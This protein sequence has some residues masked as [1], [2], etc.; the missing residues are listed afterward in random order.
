MGLGR[1]WRTPSRERSGVG[2]RELPRELEARDRLDERAE[3]LEATLAAYTACLCFTTTACSTTRRAA[4]QATPVALGDSRSIK[5]THTTPPTRLRATC[6][7]S[8]HRPGGRPH[9]ALLGLQSAQLRGGRRAR[10]CQ[11]GAVLRRQARRSPLGVLL[12]PTLSSRTS[13][14][15]RAYMPK[16]K[17][18][19]VR[20]PVKSEQSK[21]TAPCNMQRPLFQQQPSKS[22][23]GGAAAQ[24][25]GSRGRRAPGRD[26]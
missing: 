21:S 2:L 16:N 23:G 5:R 8:R 9:L 18:C 4:R 13:S 26:A 19:A 17:H 6:I 14:S 20:E 15:G 7:V 1:R 25:A 12:Q 10:L 11:L 24:G 22:I 3:F